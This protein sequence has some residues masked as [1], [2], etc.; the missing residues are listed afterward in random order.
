MRIGLVRHGQT[1]WNAIG[2]IQGQTDIALN[3]EGIRQAQ[4]LADRLGSEPPLWN[5][6]ISSD[7]R[8]AYATAKIIGDTLD[9]PLLD[10]DPLLR[11][12]SFGE[13]EGTTLEE[14]EEKYG[15]SWREQELGIESDEHLRARGRKFLER[16]L[17]RNKEENLLIVTH[18]SFIAEML[19]ELCEELE[20]QRLH[21]LSYSILERSGDSWL[22]L[23][24]NCSKHLE[25]L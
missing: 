21:N 23:L 24:H 1:D 16:R 20:D 13:I 18:G 17:L 22:P 3:G 6:V 15:E 2:R 12:R 14:R 5:A 9:I 11:E 7:L 25:H 10:P 8:R 4:A 19:L